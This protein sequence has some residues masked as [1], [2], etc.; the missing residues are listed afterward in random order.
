MQQFIEEKPF[1]KL[2]QYNVWNGKVFLCL[3]LCTRLA[4]IYEYVAMYYSI[5]MPLFAV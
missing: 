4:H 2:K 3:I 5:K 1:E